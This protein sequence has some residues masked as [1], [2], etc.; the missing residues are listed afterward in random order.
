MEKGSFQKGPLNLEVLEKLEIPEILENPQAPDCGKQRRIRPLSRDSREF[1]DFRDS[2]DSCAETTPFV[3][4][5]TP[6][7]S[8]DLQ[9][10][11]VISQNLFG[12]P[13]DVFA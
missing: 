8:P 2:R 10:E 6:F 7:S 9:Q 1:G 5:L 11:A 12:D 13:V 4:T 3:L